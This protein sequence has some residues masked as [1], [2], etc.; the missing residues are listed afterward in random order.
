MALN[1]KAAMDTYAYLM[2]GSL[3]ELIEYQFEGND[4]WEDSGIRWRYLGTAEGADRI[5]VVKMLIETSNPF[6]SCDRIV[7]CSSKTGRT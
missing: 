2:G 1:L 4:C 3:F 6:S 7:E 5:T